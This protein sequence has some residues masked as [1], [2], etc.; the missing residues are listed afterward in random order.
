[1]SLRNFLPIV[2]AVAAGVGI[3]TY[4]LKPGLEEQKR[5]RESKELLPR[6][7][8]PGNPNSPDSQTPNQT[9]PKPGAGADSSWRKT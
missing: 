9:T 1:M 6:T 4:T 7:L 8:P 3:A 2:V 5:I